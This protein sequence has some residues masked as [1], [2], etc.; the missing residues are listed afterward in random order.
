MYYIE[1]TAIQFTTMKRS[2]TKI[3]NHA[4]ISEKAIERYLIDKV[5]ALGGICLKYHN[6]NA[7]G[8]PDRICLLPNGRALWIELKSCGQRLRT[9]QQLRI[10][11]LTRLGHAAHVCDS[12]DAIDKILEPFNDFDQ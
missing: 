8:F 2:I 7:I 10:N 1:K 12:R 11:Q 6:A 5:E 4:Q 3:V 9:I